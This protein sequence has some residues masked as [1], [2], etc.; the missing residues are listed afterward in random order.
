MSREPPIGK[1]RR[2]SYYR[3]AALSTHLRQRSA[4]DLGQHMS[5]NLAQ[6]PRLQPSDIKGLPLMQPN[7][8]SYATQRRHDMVLSG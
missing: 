7:L 3:A 6:V 1:H 2:A 4:P 5:S 8:G